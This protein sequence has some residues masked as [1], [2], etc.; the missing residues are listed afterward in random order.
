METAPGTRRRATLKA[1]KGNGTV[2]LG[3]NAARS[4]AIVDMQECLVLTPALVTLIPAL[5]EL[6]RALLQDG[7]QAEVALTEADAGFDIALECPVADFARAIAILARW[8][9]GRKVARLSVNGDV[10]VQLAEP[11]I[12]IGA[13]DV[14]LPAGTFLQPSREGERILQGVV[15]DWLQGTRHRSAGRV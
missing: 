13:S 7:Q 6:L 8:A 10:A 11:R 3:F 2:H 14:L 4:H 9:K 15:L 12:R 5:R 1:A